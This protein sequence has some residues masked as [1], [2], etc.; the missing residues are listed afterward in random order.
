LER[1]SIIP[2]RKGPGRGAKRRDA[3]SWEIKNAEALGVGSFGK[4]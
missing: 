4:G 3:S 2:R 1:E